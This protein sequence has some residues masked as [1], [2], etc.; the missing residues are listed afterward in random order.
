VDLLHEYSFDIQHVKGKENVVVDALSRKNWANAISNVRGG[1]MD[2]I[3]GK[4][5][6]EPYFHAP[7]VFYHERKTPKWKACHDPLFTLCEHNSPIF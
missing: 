3:E 4:Y 7:F 1:L 2:E 5:A 6:I